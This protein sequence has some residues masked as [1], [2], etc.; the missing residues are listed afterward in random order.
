MAII[1][2]TA[3]IYYYSAIFQI[4]IS[5]MPWWWPDVIRHRIESDNYFFA[6]RSTHVGEVTSSSMS[7]MAGVQSQVCNRLTSISNIY[8]AAHSAHIGISLEKIMTKRIVRS[9]GWNQRQMSLIG[10][11]LFRFNH[12]LHFNVSSKWASL[13]TWNNALLRTF[14]S[15]RRHWYAMW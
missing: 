5:I 13:P 12:S 1:N 3:L 8:A 7:E 14:M 6:D 4:N 2:I 11:S 15:N 9:I 10:A